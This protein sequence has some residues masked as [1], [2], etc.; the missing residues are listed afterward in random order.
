VDFVFENSPDQGIQRLRYPR[1]AADLLLVLNLLLNTR[2]TSPTNRVRRHWVWAPQ[3]SASPAIWASEGYII[4]N[5]VYIVGDFP[6]V[7]ASPLDQVPADKYHSREGYAETLAVPAELAELLDAFGAL[8]ADD[9]ERF[10][11]AC[12]WHHMASA[13]W[14]YSQSLH[15]T[16][17]VN[18]IECLSSVGP[19]RNTPEGPRE[20]FSAFMRRFAP[21]KHSAS[22]SGLGPTALFKSLMRKFAPGAPSGNMLDSIYKA[23]SNITH[24][25]RLLHFDAGLPPAGLS[26]NAAIDREVGDSAVILCR[27]ALINWL[28]NQRPAASG[29]LLLTRGVS[30]AKSAKPG[31]KSGVTIIVPGS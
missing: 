13:V 26:Q 25:E 16:S 18:S 17:L 21:R 22:G 29:E 1:K 3:G 30:S 10:L 15:L 8:N 20:M 24:G 14:S 11:R 6:D 12:Y 7:D 2:I 27:G 19:T 9:R 4:P 5:L 23:R 31:T 28:W